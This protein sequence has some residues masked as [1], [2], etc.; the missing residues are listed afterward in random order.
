MQVE[1][2]L[3]LSPAKILI[4]ATFQPDFQLV[5]TLGADGKRRV[6]MDLSVTKLNEHPQKLYLQSFQMLLVGYTNVRAGA[7]TH[8]HLSF[9]T[10]QS[11]SNIGLQVFTASDASGAK[12]T[13]DSKLWD[14][15]TLDDSVVPHFATCN[16]QRRYKL[17]VLMG[18]QCQSGEHAGRVFFVQAR[19]PVRISSGIQRSRQ[20]AKSEAWTEDDLAVNA[21]FEMSQSLRSE[22]SCA[23][24][25]APPTYDEVVKHQSIVG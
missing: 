25:S 21:D 24:Y 10:L 13:I 9:W 4:N 15:I 8:G 22:G 17:E 1:Y 6:K 18:W 5:K 19:T 12:R 2:V 7:A 11:L 14:G 3:G 23:R 16:L 20:S